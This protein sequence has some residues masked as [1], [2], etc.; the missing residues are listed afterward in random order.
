MSIDTVSVSIPAGTWTID[1]THSRIGFVARHMMVTK[2]RGSFGEYSADIEIAENPL[3]SQL[4]AEVQ[5]ASIDTGNADRDQHLR[6]NDFFDIE[7]FPTMSLVASGFEGAGDT[8]AMHADLTIKGVTRPVRFELEFDGVGQ[9]PWGGT[10]A[11][12]TAT[13]TINRKDWGI[14]WNAP[15]E[16]GGVLVG[17]QVRI[18]LDVQLVKS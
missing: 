18:E 16:T 1:P 12:F 6:T 9:D 4:S 8:Y 3:D 14:E 11:G 13:A 5:M 7:R 10:R 17:E 15:L 2:V